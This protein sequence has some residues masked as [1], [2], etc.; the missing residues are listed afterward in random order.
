[1]KDLSVKQYGSR[2]YRKILYVGAKTLL[3]KILHFDR[4]KI[5]FLSIKI[6]FN[7]RKKVEPQTLYPDQQCVCRRHST[8]SE[9]VFNYLYRERSRLDILFQDEIWQ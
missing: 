2:T 7:I 8:E 9:Y 5:D 1:M 6:R 3:G 4:E